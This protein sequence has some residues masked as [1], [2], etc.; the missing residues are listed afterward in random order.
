MKKQLILIAISSAISITIL[1]ACGSTETK[2]TGNFT[3]GS[4]TPGTASST[5]STPAS[6]NG[7][8]DTCTNFSGNYSAV[9]L[10]TLSLVQNGC[11]SLVYTEA[12]TG[13]ANFCKAFGIQ[14]VSFT[15][16]LDGS[17]NS[18]GYSA[19]I[20]GGT[21][22]LTQTSGNNSQTQALQFSNHPCDPNNGAAGLEA[23]VTN[24]QTNDGVT[25]SSS[26][27]E[28]WSKM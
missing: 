2:A 23:Q 1:S 26:S 18:N 21:L 13:D 28:P 4:K 8:A 11:A 7:Q 24:T 3:A 17:T 16:P 6:P 27:C 10:A 14:N 25:V 15:I 9:G 20:S 5:P 12:C 19:S 22:T